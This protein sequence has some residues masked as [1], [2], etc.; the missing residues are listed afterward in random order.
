MWQQ[1]SGNEAVPLPRHGAYGAPG[2]PTGCAAEPAPE[3]AEGA[4]RQQGAG[5]EQPALGRRIGPAVESPPAR[6]AL[7]PRSPARPGPSPA[8]G[9][10]TMSRAALLGLRGLRAPGRR[11]WSAQTA[12]ACPPPPPAAVRMGCASGFWGDTAASGGAGAGAGAAPAGLARGR[13]AVL[14]PLGRPPRRLGRCG[15]ALPGLKYR[16]D[17]VGRSK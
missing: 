3:A 16:N 8:S 13:G 14:V 15:A 9:R 11:A 1:G 6:R 10:D 4:G 12:G 2:R 5:A 17:P 7:R